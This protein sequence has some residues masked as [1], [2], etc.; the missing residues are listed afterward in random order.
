M[1]DPSARP[2]TPLPDGFLYDAFISYRHQEPDMSWVRHELV[3]R[4]DAAGLRI[5]L[6]IRH[7]DA[8]A[9]ALNQMMEA[10]EQSR[11]T[12]AVLSNNYLQGNFAEVE[13]LMAQTL[14]I[15]ERQYRLLPV[16]FERDCKIPLRIRM[17]SYLDLAD[18]TQQA[19]TL[20][21]LIAAIRTLPTRR[22]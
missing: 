7:F 14:G 11:R 10:V 2:T 12:I 19:E 17:L 5:C 22:V 20:H 3:P 13:N 1:I 16:R 18:L 6:D 8:G 21:R 4:L 15:E 9:P